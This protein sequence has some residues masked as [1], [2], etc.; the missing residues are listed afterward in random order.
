MK[1][2]FRSSIVILFFFII[3]FGHFLLYAS[4]QDDE[5]LSLPNHILTYVGDPSCDNQD[6]KNVV[7]DYQSNQY[8]LKENL[9]LGLAFFD[10]EKK[11]NLFSCTKEN[12]HYPIS[13]LCNLNQELIEFYKICLQIVPAWLENGFMVRIL[14]SNTEILIE[15]NFDK[16]FYVE[17]TY[18]NIGQS[19]INIGNLLVDIFLKRTNT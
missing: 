16:V 13:Y 11:L 9:D 18:L 12:V 8:K 15:E 5:K 17:T 1:S 6:I 7:Q 14:N 3:L 4:H 10:N 2:I 19:N